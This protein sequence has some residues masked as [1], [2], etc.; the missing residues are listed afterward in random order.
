VKKSA[1]V[2]SVSA[3]EDHGTRIFINTF[4]SFFL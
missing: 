2:P 4:L 1:I 3:R